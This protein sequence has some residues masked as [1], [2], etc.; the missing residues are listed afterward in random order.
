MNNPKDYLGTE[1]ARNKVAAAMFETM[2]KMA[3]GDDNDVMVGHH[4]GFEVHGDIKTENEIPS[5][6]CLLFDHTI[7]NRIFGERAHDVLIH[8]ALTPCE[9][10][11]SLA[12]Q[13][14]EEEQNRRS[15]VLAE[16]E[17]MPTVAGN[18]SEWTPS[19]DV[20]ATIA[21]TDPSTVNPGFFDMVRE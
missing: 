10:R 14:L 2:I 18:Y 8:L 4:I 5:A 11:D 3:F 13:Y 20:Q 9:E 6:D 7:M 17:P 1:Q 12:A 21:N 16:R 19:A 15:T